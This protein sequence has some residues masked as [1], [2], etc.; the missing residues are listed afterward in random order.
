[1][2]AKILFFQDIS[3][4]Q[5]DLVGGKG[6][7]LGIMTNAGI[8]VPNGF[9]VTS[10]VYKDFIAQNSLQAFLKDNSDGHAIRTRL[11]HCPLPEYLERQVAEALAQFDSRIY[12]SV[13]SS[14]TAEDLPFASFAGQQDTYLN[15]AGL[16][17]ILDAIRNCWASLYTDRAIIY[18]EKQSINPEQ[19]YM[20]VVVQKMVIS[21]MSGIMFSADP[22][23]ENRNAISIDAGFGLGEA[24]VSGIVSPD[25][26][27]YDK[28]TGRITD[29]LI[30]HK[31]LA[32]YPLA[33][34]GTEQVE[35][36]DAKASSQVLDD[37]TIIRLAQLGEKIEAYYK[38]PQDIEWCIE[39][40]EIFIVQSRAITSL[41]PLAEPQ[42][43]D[44]MLHPY[45]SFG[46]A[47]MMLA[48]ISPMGI[49]ILRMFFRSG[50]DPLE[51]YTPVFIKQAAG[52]IY[53][54]TSPILQ[55]KP[56]RK[57]LPKLLSNID[58]L[59]SEAVVSLVERDDFDKR[60]AKRRGAIKG[61]FKFAHKILPRVLK[62][63]LFE[64]TSDTVQKI[65]VFVQS[66]ISS[67]AAGMKAAENT[68]DTLRAIYNH[69]NIFQSFIAGLAPGI[70]PGLISMKRLES[71]EKKLLGSNKYALEI[72]KGLDGNVT[73]EMGLLAGD[74]ADYV[75][76]S[77]L[78]RREFEH[79]EYASFFTRIA[80]LPDEDE[81]KRLLSS[82][83]KRYGVR[84]AGEIDLAAARWI[85][86][87]EPFVNS[88]LSLVDGMKDG[89]HREEFRQTKAEALAAAQEFLAEIAKKH[90][91]G[92]AKKVD[93]TIKIARN[94]MAIREHP[95]F[96]MMNIFYAAKKALLI[97]ADKLVDEGRLD[98]R[99]D[100]FMLGFMELDQ[101]LAG[102]DNLKK[103]VAER[104]AAY[105]RFRQFTPP[106]LLTSD[107]EMIKTT[108]NK[109]NLPAGAMVGV[110]V[111]AGV[112][113][114]VAKVIFDPTDANI[115]KGEILVAPYTDP[116]WT[117]L[118]INAAGLV[119]EIGG[120]LTHGTVVAREYGIPAVV[121]CEKATSL[122]KTGQK[123]RLDGSN[124]FVLIME[125]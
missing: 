75:R 97:E 87:P 38:Y 23:S 121:C 89:Q 55:Y 95:K 3:Q 88:V 31:K 108:I 105:D 119:T 5:F 107:G 14:A 100:I 44:G 47:Q 45:I 32:I 70:L 79:K 12:F 99:Q 13:R 15:V 4:T 20:S 58:L 103:I 22:V 57:I 51:S 76:K 71:L 46:H 48:P 106:R 82:F 68:R 26:Y 90:G 34:G 6:V 92:K 64:D 93:K 39:K 52:R 73:T 72:M 65:E 91:Q 83:M 102:G 30:S 124:G 42:P 86:N 98:D 123:I 77:P 80:A 66:T 1:M 33:D 43:G 11:R 84:A 115:E 19:V 9:C 125:D 118:F 49:D 104:K 2:N 37:D 59:I 21:E 122:I 74:L 60:I 35:L 111:S 40:G 101:A 78:L 17:N 110:G 24:L 113:E 63:L 18:R 94:C 117:T 10:D 120:L 62:R 56:L 69:F 114:G 36:D 25:I 116:G 28:L 112:I 7:N 27:K 54:D 61:F 96:M 16:T 29:K 109:K 85:E 41:F 50:D 81:F 53:L 8:P 67:V